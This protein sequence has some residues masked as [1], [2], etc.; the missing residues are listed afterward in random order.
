[1]LV[2]SQKKGKQ[3]NDMENLNFFCGNSW[4]KKN[5]IEIWSDSTR[6]PC[7]SFKIFFT[8]FFFTQ[9]AGT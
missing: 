1:M 8:L 4:K 3:E 6:N 5:I 2:P 7:Q 9:T